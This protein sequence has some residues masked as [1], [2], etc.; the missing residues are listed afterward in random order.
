MIRKIAANTRPTQNTTP[1]THCLGGGGVV[2]NVVVVVNVA[3]VE[4]AAELIVDSV[5]AVIIL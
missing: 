4:S 1:Y 3:V 2:V 5:G